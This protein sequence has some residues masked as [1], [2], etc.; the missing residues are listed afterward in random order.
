MVMLGQNLLAALKKKTTV[1][2]LA[3][4]I[5]YYRLMT[6]YFVCFAF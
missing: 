6:F 2:C 5:M 1:N 3:N 4:Y